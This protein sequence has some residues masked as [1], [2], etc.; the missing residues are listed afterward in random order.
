MK[1]WILQTGEPLQIDKS[2]LRPM[3]AI[4]LSKA[5]T[6]KGH[7]VTLWSSDF[8]HFSKQHRYG[9]AKIIKFSDNLTIRLIKSNGYTSHVGLGRLLDHAQLGWNLKKMLKNEE[10]PDIA[11]I[12][13]PPI[14]PAL[15][16]S[17]WL[18]RHKI[19][20]MVDVKDAWPSILLRG[21]PKML[22]PFGIL[23]LIP[24]FLAM[25]KIFR[26]ATSIS[27]ITKPYL[28]WCNRSAGRDVSEFDRVTP[29]TSQDSK[30]SN[31]EI[32]FAN[33][34]LEKFGVRKDN[35]FKVTF[36]GTLNSAFDFMPIIRVARSLR[37][38][39]VVAGDGPQL[40]ELKK[41]C[42]ADENIIFTGWI[43]SGTAHSLMQISSIM[44]APLR[45]LPDFKMSLPNKFFDAMQNSKPI[46]TSISGYAG[47]F[48]RDSEIGIEYS[49]ENIEELK[50][51]L[52][53]LMVDPCRLERMG[54]NAKK[55]YDSKF[56]FENIYNELVGDLEKIS[57]MGT[58]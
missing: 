30:Y 52:S 7:N 55:V 39:L 3:R 33:Y 36:I 27:S 6:D 24:Y 8:D 2:G 31:S 45:D 19:K 34:E 32:E 37:F 15:I 18:K 17:V 10:A 21:I 1:V 20:Y 58:L 49:N 28:D 51:I 56:N 4:N 41:I 22:K 46:L 11:F 26:G 35:S 48:I 42:E 47:E 16:L 23:A 38:M 57:K 5:L 54:K 44:L 43:N 25:R 12:G 14:E 29:L 13:Y 9:S 53:S 40:L 50:E